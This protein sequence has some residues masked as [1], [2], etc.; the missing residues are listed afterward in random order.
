M[1]KE[2]AESLYNKNKK[3][4]IKSKG[5]DYFF[6]TIEKISQDR[7][8]IRSFSGRRVGRTQEL[9]FEKIAGIWE[10]QNRKDGK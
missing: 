4:F 10:Y 1:T 8:T 2:I 9:L 5:D 6:C 3:V 7:L